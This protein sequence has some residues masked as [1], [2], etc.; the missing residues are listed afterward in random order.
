MKKILVFTMSLL[1]TT[2]VFA[3]NSTTTNNG[4][5]TA[6]A[7]LALGLLYGLAKAV[8][9]VGDD[10]ESESSSTPSY[11][12]S[13]GGVKN[14]YGSDNACG[15]TTYS[16]YCNDGSWGGYVDSCN[17]PYISWTGNRSKGNGY[18]I[19]INEASNKLCQ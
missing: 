5:D 18:D 11:S 2:S 9:S 13:G 14:M 6:G 16:V 19:S 8:G 4:S 7:L 3:S 10:T 17:S 15:G 12:H 1:L